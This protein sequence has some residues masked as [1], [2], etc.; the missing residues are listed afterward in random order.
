MDEK[1][2]WTNLTQI[3]FRFFTYHTTGAVFQSVVFLVLKNPVQQHGYLFFVP[4]NHENLVTGESMDG[5]EEF[6]PPQA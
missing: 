6:I 4:G 5:A 2:A 1:I 3:F